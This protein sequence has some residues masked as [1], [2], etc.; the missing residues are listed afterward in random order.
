MARLTPVGIFTKWIL[1][2]LLVA[3]F[4]YGVLGPRFGGKVAEKIKS[5]GVPLPAISNEKTGTKTETSPP[6]AKFP[7]P[8]VSV[9]ARK[10]GSRP[11]AM[12]GE[13]PKMSSTDGE[14][15]P[16]P[17]RRRRKRRKSKTEET[18]SSEGKSERK[19]SGEKKD[20]PPEVPSDP[21]PVIPGDGG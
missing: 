18:K 6:A 1:V 16:K 5:T 11:V 7:P 14:E 20:A 15:E 17:K 4:G 21:P 8:E 2:P 3:G 19:S 9:S 12:P 10:V 13:A